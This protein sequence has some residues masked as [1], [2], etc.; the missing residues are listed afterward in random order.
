V[1]PNINTSF[2]VGGWR[3]FAITAFCG[4]FAHIGLS[5][6]SAGFGVHFNIS[7]SVSFRKDRND[8][9]TGLSKRDSQYPQSGGGYM[10]YG[11]DRGFIETGCLSLIF[12]TKKLIVL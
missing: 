10:P 7:S 3:I 2:V 8:F 1:G 12:L 11:R 9:D 5:A 4:A 6:L